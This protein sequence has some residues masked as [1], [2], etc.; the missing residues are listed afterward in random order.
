MGLA[1]PDVATENADICLLAA[2][3]S[4]LPHLL[5]V[6]RRAIKQ[7]LF[8]SLGVSVLAV[9]LTIPGVLHYPGH[10]QL[11]APDRVSARELVQL[12]SVSERLRGCRRR[13]AGSQT[14]AARSGSV[15]AGVVARISR[16]P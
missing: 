1:G 9:G 12:P 6:S 4:K 8:F 3:L 5:D 11:G 2:H 14:R 15:A 10:R 16:S 13:S 7:S